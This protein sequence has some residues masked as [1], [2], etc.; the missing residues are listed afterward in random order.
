MSLGRHRS[1]A[2]AREPGVAALTNLVKMQH[3][4]DRSDADLMQALQAGHA[5]ALGALYDRHAG[6]VFGIALKLLGNSEDA[7]DLT[8]EIFLQLWRKPGAYKA[9]RGA[10][11]S[12]LATL[13]RSRAIDLLRSRTSTTNVLQR[14]RR[15]FLARGAADS[16]LDVASGAEQAQA[17]RTALAKLPKRQQEVLWLR[18]YERY[19]FSQIARHLDLPLGTVKTRSRQGLLAL[20]SHMLAAMPPHPHQSESVNYEK[21]V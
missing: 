9:S 8:Q 6:T 1:L 2:A 20:R 14:W 13:T 21:G 3:L 4:V 15:L 12:Y 11:R 5:N 18:F 17:V 10:L 7:E 19:S 16:L